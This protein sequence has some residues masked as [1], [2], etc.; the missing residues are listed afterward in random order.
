MEAWSEEPGI[1]FQEHY[2]YNKGDCI[3]DECVDAE[4]W[5]SCLLEEYDSY[6][7]FK[8]DYPGA[9]PKE[10][11]DIA[12]GEVIVGGFCDEYGKWNI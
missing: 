7:E 5:D 6:K 1:G 2:I 10:A 3:E 12:D 9:P 4:F 8:R 11:F